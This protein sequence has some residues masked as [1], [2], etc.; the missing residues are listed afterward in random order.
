M[1]W[2]IGNEGFR[3]V[4]SSYVPDIIGSN[5][6]PLLRGLLHQYGMRL[7]DVKEWAVHPGGRAIID[8]IESSLNLK[9]HDL[10]ASR[11]VLRD[12][13]NMS[14]PTI[15]FVLKEMLEH[16]HTERALVGAMAFGPG[17]TV[18]TALLE[19][20]GCATESDSRARQTA[21]FPLETSAV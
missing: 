7:E 5:L 18:E 21:L 2:D 13:G 8:K 16:A 3:M 12:Y 6:E 9:E 15:L 4:L 1:A 19:R 20:I 14:S 10:D 17:L 11:N